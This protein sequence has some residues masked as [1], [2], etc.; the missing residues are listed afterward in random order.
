MGSAGPE[1]MILQGN[2]ALNKLPGLTC[3][4]SGWLHATVVPAVM[5]GAGKLPGMKTM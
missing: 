3:C 1:E 4:T 2:P 5:P